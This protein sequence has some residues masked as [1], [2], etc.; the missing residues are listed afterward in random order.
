[1]RLRSLA[2]NRK[3]YV[4][5]KMKRQVRRKKEKEKEMREIAYVGSITLGPIADL[6]IILF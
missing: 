6:L 4:I 2:K 5:T 1:M 3:M